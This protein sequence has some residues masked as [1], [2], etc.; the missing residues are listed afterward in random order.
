MS[1]TQQ[2]PSLSVENVRND[3]IE[4]NDQNE[5]SVLIAKSSSAS[6]VNNTILLSLLRSAGSERSLLV[7]GTEAGVMYARVTQHSGTGRHSY[8]PTGDV[9]PNFESAV[10]LKM[11]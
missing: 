11:K 8:S 2:R 4:K 3:V 6:R 1:T 9:P 5:I 10:I 7:I